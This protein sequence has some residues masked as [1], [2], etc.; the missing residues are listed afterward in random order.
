MVNTSW[1]FSNVL[2]ISNQSR[3]QALFYTTVT[4]YVVSGHGLTKVGLKG[5]KGTVSR[6]RHVR[7]HS[8]YYV[9]TWVASH[10]RE[11]RPPQECGSLCEYYAFCYGIVILQLAR[12]FNMRICHTWPE[13]NI[14]RR[15]CGEN[16]NIKYPHQESD[17]QLKQGEKFVGAS[18]R[19]WTHFLTY[20]LRTLAGSSIQLYV[21]GSRACTRDFDF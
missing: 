19:P 14:D 5:T 11:V 18:R 1:T 4:L 6:H 8:P 2:N 3:G 15:A 21:H 9:T 13:G 12:T 10:S 7:V 17:I 20:Y 16:V